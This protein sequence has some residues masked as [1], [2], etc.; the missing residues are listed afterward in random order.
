MKR[1]PLPIYLTDKERA[2]LEKIQRALGKKT[3]S[4]TVKAMIEFLSKLSFIN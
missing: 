1:K 4:S 3:L 2:D